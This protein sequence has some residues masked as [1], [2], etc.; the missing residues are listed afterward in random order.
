MTFLSAKFPFLRE[1]VVTDEG[2]RLNSEMRLVRGSQPWWTLY[3]FLGNW[4]SSWY[5][6]EMFWKG[7]SLEKR[8]SLLQFKVIIMNPLLKSLKKQVTC[9]ICLDTYTEPKTISCL[10]TFCCGCLER[11]ARV[12]QRQW[13]FRCP[14]CQAEIDLPQGNRFDRLPKSFFSQKSVRCPWSGRSPSHTEAT[15]GNLLA[16]YGRKSTILLLFVWGVYL[17]NLRHRRPPRPCVWRA[18][19]SSARG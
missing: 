8:T 16:A 13:K 15:T 12:S 4:N 17:S 6:V 1:G 18:W 10:H 7:S 11:R 19:K 2:M 5:F 9:S 3:C 14:E